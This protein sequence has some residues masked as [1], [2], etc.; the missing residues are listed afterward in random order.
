MQLSPKNLVQIC[1]FSCLI[2]GIGVLIYVAG[3]HAAASGQTEVQGRLNEIDS[4]IIRLSALT[5]RISG[6]E[7]KLNSLSSFSTRG[8]LKEPPIYDVVLN[9][10]GSHKD[11]PFL[12]K[13]DNPIVLMAF[14]D[15]Q[16]APCRKFY[17]QSF[18]RLKHDFIDK[19]QLRFILR[20]FPLSSHL[21]A[22]GAAELAHC[23]GEQGKYW[24]VFQALS[25]NQVLVDKGLLSKV[26]EKI[27]ALNTN[28][29]AQ[30]IHSGRYAKEISLDIK[31]GISLGA[32]GAPGF[33]LGRQIDENKFSGVFI[34]GAQPY[35]VIVAEIAKLL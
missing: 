18:P 7:K 12:G 35:Q 16:C 33:F 14:Y 6:L 11:D 8:R 17:K 3:F 34:R 22:K 10:D 19:G 24:E 23:A 15:Y 25:V 28:L 5:S 31:A 4:K 2:C 32:R 13:K 27:S 1:F 20:D 26:V 29:L 21:Y 9:S 30:C